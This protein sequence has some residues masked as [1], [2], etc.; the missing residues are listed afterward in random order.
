MQLLAFFVLTPTAVLCSGTSEFNALFGPSHDAGAVMQKLT[1]MMSESKQKLSLAERHH[2]KVVKKVRKEAAAYLDAEA[3]DY[4]KYLNSYSAELAKESADFQAAV[5]QAKEGIKKSEAEPSSIN[6]WK[7]PKVEQRAKLGAQVAAA[8]RTIKRNDRHRDRSVREAEERA[9]ETLEDESQKVGMKVGDMTPL[10]DQAKKTLEAAAEKAVPA[11]AAAKKVAGPSAAVASKKVDLEALE[12]NLK[13]A[14]AK[15]L[16][17]T[18]DANKKLD[19]FLTKKADDVAAKTVKTLADLEGQQ[20]EEI[21]KVLGRTDAPAKSAAPAKKAQAAKG[22]ASI[23]VAA[24]VAKT[25]AKAVPAKKV[26]AAAAK[27]ATTPAVKAVA[28]VA[29][30]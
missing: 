28:A 18:K 1:G 22:K 13:K 12:D 26:Q 16:A 15:N 17:A 30:K 8:E 11:V 10:V 2:K 21:A 3:A 29:K 23:K 6:D 7:D 25:V 5:D 27:K 24:P 14:T 19:G 4:G 20:K 9:E